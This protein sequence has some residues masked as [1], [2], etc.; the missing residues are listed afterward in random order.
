MSIEMNRQDSPVLAIAYD[1][2]VRSVIAANLASCAVKTVQCSSFAEA[3]NFV[4]Q[5]ECR[6]ILVDLMA[7][8]KAKEEEKAVAYTLT[9]YYP[10]LRVK[11]MG[12]MIVPMAMAGDTRQAK[13]VTDFLA[14]N[15]A[16]FKPRGLRAFRR[17][18][19]RIPTRI[20][21]DRGHTLNISYGGAFVSDIDWELFP[22]GKGIA[23]TFPDFGIDVEGIVARTQALGQNHPAGIG[24]KFTHMSPVL[25]STL[26]PLFSNEGIHRA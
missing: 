5:N 25:E 24:V 12:M 14:K 21:T 9:G 26:S 7:L 22:V 17:I 3:E 13:S 15:C 19:L 16:A 23:M 4:L 1:E 18:D 2:T 11:A 20:G 10:T 8:L 6:G